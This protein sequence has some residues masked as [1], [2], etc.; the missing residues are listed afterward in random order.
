MACPSLLCTL[1]VSAALYLTEIF[2]P[3][4]ASLLFLNDITYLYEK[5]YNYF[6]KKMY[7]HCIAL[8]VCKTAHLF[9]EFGTINVHS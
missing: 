4:L 8:P 2:T 1:A 3:K 7:V 5:L 6:A 9:H